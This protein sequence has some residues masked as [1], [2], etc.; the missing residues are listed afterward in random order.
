METSR[1]FFGESGTGI[2]RLFTGETTVPIFVNLDASA[3]VNDLS[4]P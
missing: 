2:L 4:F 3:A 1:L